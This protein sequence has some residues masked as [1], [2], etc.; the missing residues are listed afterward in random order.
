MNWLL[1]R[2]NEPSTWRGLV[3]LLT[4][5]G[6][7]IKPE[8]AEAIITA[9][10]AIAGLIGVVTKDKP[11][12]PDS[13]Q[14]PPIELHGRSELPVDTGMVPRPASYYEN[15]ANPVHYFGNHRIV[16]RVQPELQSKPATEQESG[17]NG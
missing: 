12:A 5:F 10:I 15:N 17:W 9:G 13:T 1:N 4:A 16:D 2:L 11:D 14:I 6:L 8:L 3:W 7:S